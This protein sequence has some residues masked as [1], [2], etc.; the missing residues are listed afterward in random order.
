VF[1][2]IYT[3]SWSLS[4]YPQPILNVQ[5]QSTHGFSPDFSF[6]NVLGFAALTA[7]SAS[8]LYSSV[9]RREY[10]DRH[11]GSPEPTARFNDLAFAAHALLLTAITATQFWPRLW[12]WPKQEDVP[13]VDDG[14]EEDP[15]KQEALGGQRGSL[16]T[17]LMCGGAVVFVAVLSVVVAAKKNSSKGQRQTNSLDWIDVVYS[18]QYVKLVLTI[19]KY[20]PQVISNYLRKSTSGWSISTIG[21]DFFGGV[22]SML[23]LVLDSA[24]G[25]DWSGVTGNPGKVGLSVISL[26]FDSVFLVQHY[27]LYR[28]GDEAEN[29]LQSKSDDETTP[30]IRGGA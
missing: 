21:F 22:L 24:V 29:G 10:A 17:K 8:F 13:V 18:L 12:G 15:S 20:I 16:L 5:R 30:L 9:I 27:V 11:P 7:S 14:D 28:Y 23:Q 25:D 1:G 19:Y 3:L 6:T 2:W 26:F 4:F